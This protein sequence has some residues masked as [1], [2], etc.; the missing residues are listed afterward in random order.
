MTLDPVF[1]LRYLLLALGALIAGTTYAAWRLAGRCGPAL[2]WTLGAL[3]IGGVAC[4]AAVALNPGRW[5][6][7]QTP[8]DARWMVLIDRTLSM[9]TPDVGDAPRWDTAVTVA[10]EVAAERP[11]G[12]DIRPIGAA[13]EPA[14]QA[15]DLA[16]LAPDHPHTDLVRP[17]IEA[18]QGSGAGVVQGILLISDGGQN[19]EV[20]TAA[21]INRAQSLAVPIH[22]V[23]LG[24]PV[25]RRDLEIKP[26]RRQLVAFQGQ[27]LR[28]PFELRSAGLGPLRPRVELTDQA[29]RVIAETHAEVA[30]GGRVTGVLEFEPQQRGHS[31]FRLRITPPPEDQI[32]AN[33]EAA[34][35]VT[36]LAGKV[37]IFMAEGVPY[38]D[39][40][41]LVQLLREQPNFEITA[42][43][44]LGSD[45]FFKLETDSARAREIEAATFPETAEELAAFDIV[46]FGKGA[47]YFLTPARLERMQAFVRD[48]G[49]AI[50]FARG[51]PY[52]GT[53]DALEPLEP[54]VWG[55]RIGAEFKLRPVAGGEES[56]LF[57]DLL[58]APDDA[59][60]KNL[61]PLLDADQVAAVKTFGQ[62]LAEGEV[63]G[64][65][66]QF[67]FPAVISRR[68]G[69]GIVVTINAE[70]L[71]R[72]DFLPGDPNARN[73][74]E[75]FWSQLMQWTATYS[76]FLPGEEYSLRLGRSLIRAGEPVQVRIRRRNNDAGAGSP[77]LTVSGGTAAPAEIEPLPVPGQ[78]V[79]WNALVAPTEPG[80]YRVSLRDRQHPETAGPEALLTV[81]SPADDRQSPGADR[82]FLEQL[83]QATGGRVLTPRNATTLFDTHPAQTPASGRPEWESAWDRPWL[84]ACMLGCFGTEWFLRRRNG[85]R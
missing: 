55:D 43:Y 67:R 58:P 18:L 39:S 46:L 9:R 70:G 34:L 36:A 41:F 69:K 13:L 79:E 29:G 48:Q 52:A 64:A 38:W 33:N 26:L 84:L 42:I 56:G 35:A 25:G 53:L 63:V 83:A 82:A 47:E 7:P 57:G 81:E 54:V 71:W 15:P 20:D 51:K 23:P 10:S 76:E 17:M 6:I 49:G 72:W 75:E 19:R 21:L 11:G 80:T 73:R 30:D 32:E 85:L 2:R 61:P 74:Y 16:K 22:V 24:A 28:I 12:V 27:K 66:R 65:G 77:F 50:V 1:E 59:V 5:I 62:V 31:E 45:R 8:P 4:L 14:C 44:R 40:K 37:R 60:W 78:G 68:F 3:R